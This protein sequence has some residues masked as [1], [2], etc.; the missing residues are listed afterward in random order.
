[1]D[2]CHVISPG[3]VLLWVL[4]FKFSK[5]D[6]S[7]FLPH[8]EQCVPY[9]SWW[10]AQPGCDLIVHSSYKPGESVSF[11]TVCYL[12]RGRE[13]MP[14]LIQMEARGQLQP[15]LLFTMW[16]QGSL[17]C[18]LAWWLYLY[19]L[20]HLLTQIYIFFKNWI[21]CYYFTSVICHN[22]WIFHCHLI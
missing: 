1:M 17:S 7:V 20:S 5:T 12:W 21:C 15:S 8:F 2:F 13:L 9:C 4:R 16:V 18:C 10:D 22:Y 6:A 11:R 3:L 14:C 19:P